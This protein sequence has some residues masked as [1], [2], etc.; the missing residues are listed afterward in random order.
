MVLKNENSVSLRKGFWQREIKNQGDGSGPVSKTISKQAGN[1]LHHM[2][3]AWWQHCIRDPDSC[4]AESAVK[5]RCTAD[6]T[7][8]LDNSTD[9]LGLLVKLKTPVPEETRPQS[10]ASWFHAVNNT[11]NPPGVYFHY[12]W[13]GLVKPSHASV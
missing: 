13:G 3:M 2:S 5:K 12:I 7:T 8:K 11:E 6:S 10:Q 4:C 1:Q 9:T